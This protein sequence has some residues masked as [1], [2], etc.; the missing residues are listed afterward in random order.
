MFDSP[1][2]HCPVCGQMVALDQAQ[3]ECARKH[4]CSPDTACPLQKYFTGVDFSPDQL[5]EK[6]PGS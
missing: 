3:A 1:M 2:E 4:G 6:R 5:K